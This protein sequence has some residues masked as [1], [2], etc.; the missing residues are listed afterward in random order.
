MSQKHVYF[1]DE[2][3]LIKGQ[4]IITTI[5]FLT[6]PDVNRQSTRGTS[7]FPV[8]EYQMLGNRI[9]QSGSCNLHLCLKPI[10]QLLS[11]LCYCHSNSFM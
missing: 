7:L 5:L 11:M 6:T 4:E 10:R 1:C 2:L 8:I 9:N 3:L